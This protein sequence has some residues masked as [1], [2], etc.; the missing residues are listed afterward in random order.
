MDAHQAHGV[1]AGGRL[2]GVA[3]RE[4]GRGAEGLE[5]GDVG[6]DAAAADDVAPRG[7]DG[8][9]AEAGEKGARE[10]DGGARL[11]AEAGVED[12]GG[13]IARADGDAVGRLVDFGLGAE[14]AEKLDR[15]EDVADQGEVFEDD[16]FVREEG[17]REH[18]EGRVLV[19][20]R[21]VC[22]GKGFAAFD[23]ELGHASI[24]PKCGGMRRLNRASVR[25]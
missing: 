22:A 11:R 24:I 5:A 25:G 4:V 3:G 14:G 17:G 18:G 12:R 6:V 21:R 15:R 13:E 7:G 16:G 1:A 9:L 20:R 8:D 23:D 2:E 10:E 19:A